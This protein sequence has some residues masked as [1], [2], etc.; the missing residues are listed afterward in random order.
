MASRVKK[1]MERNR[2]GEAP[3][4]GFYLFFRFLFLDLW[5]KFGKMISKGI[6][7]RPRPLCLWDEI[8]YIDKENYFTI[9]I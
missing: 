2:R 7:R 9:F 1:L 4:A 6:P 3:P 8:S 5:I